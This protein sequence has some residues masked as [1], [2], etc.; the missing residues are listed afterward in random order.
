MKKIIVWIILSFFVTINSFS[1]FEEIDK[2]VV[3]IY[4]IFYSQAVKKHKS[5]N[6]LSYLKK[7]NSAINNIKNNSKVSQKNKSILDDLQ[8]LNNEKIFELEFTNSNKEWKDIITNSSLYSSFENKV[9]NPDYLFLENWIWYSYDFEKSYHFNNKKISAIDLERNSI[10]PKTDLIIYN[11]WIVSFVNDAKKIKI[12]TD[13]ILYWVAEK[14]SIL[15]FLKKNKRNLWIDIDNQLKQ[16]KNI[17]ENITQNE[18]N[19]DNIIKIIYEYILNNIEYTNNFSLDDY[20]IYS[21]VQ[22]FVN[23]NWVCEWYTELFT[24]ML[25]FNLIESQIIKWDVI[26]AEDFPNIWHAWNKIWDYYYDVTFDDPI[27]AK[28]NKIF[29]EYEYFKLPKDLFY[30]NRFDF[31]DTPEYL[32]NTNMETRKNLV[33]TNLASLTSKYQKNNYN[34][35]KKVNFKKENNI[36]I[37]E[38]ITVDDILNI[39][40]SY[41]FVN[42]KIFFKEKTRNV[43]TLAYTILEDDSIETLLK[44]YNYDLNDEIILEWRQDSWERIYILINEITYQN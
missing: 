10:N 36:E 34:I 5:D 7:L 38:D 37:N 44:N 29:S 31:W 30:T 15:N 8:K 6:W 19:N 1:Y 18:T 43:S 17:S 2:K 11:D 22:T 4:N 40:E 42:Y 27:G 13:D 35:L 32:K 33:Q 14:N 41:V 21:W 16:I 25:S 20:R 12:V 9:F 24:L 28:R 26:D 3:T 23:K 39:Y